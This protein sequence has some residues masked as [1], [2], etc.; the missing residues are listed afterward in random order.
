MLKLTQEMKLSQKLD[1]RM[2]Q[3]LKLLPLTTLQLTQRINEELEQNPLLQI[4]ETVEQVQEKPKTSNDEGGQVKSET[5]SESERNG[6]FTEAEWLKYM[7]DGYDNHYGTRQEYDP[8]VEERESIH[9]YTYGMTESLIEQLGMIAKTETDREIGEFIIGSLNDDGFLELTDEEIASDLNMPV[10]DISRM[11]SVIQQFDPPG[12]AARN[13]RECL[14]IQLMEK[15]MENSIAWKIIDKHFADL[16]GRKHKEILRSLQIS[17]NELK[18]AIDVIATLT[19]KP[20]GIFNDTSNTAIVPDILVEKLDGEYV[21]I[22]NDRYI[23]HLNINAHYR[24]LLEKGSNTSTDT[25]KYLVDKL[26]SAR[27]FINSIEQRRSTILRVST[28][29]IERQKEFLDHGISHLKP[30]TLQDIAENIGVAISTVQRVTTGKYIQTPQ[31]VFELKNFFTQR[32]ASSDGSDDYSAKTVK[33]KLKTL[34]EKE[35]PYKPLSDQ[36]IT[37]L[38][39]KEGISISRR[40]IAKYRDELQISPAR[41]RKQ[42]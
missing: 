27:W 2:I 41:L 12:I 18:K 14:L 39:N 20:G 8:N 37:D 10:E 33:D 22:L 29:I 5:T 30:M 32:I 40:A 36:K 19:P 26:N 25:R 6:D 38:L 9:T 16:T 15:G 31:G 11:V 28:A 4:D 35:D 24:K 34:I 42:F 21:V 13:L 3:S 1:F 17:E 23:P 7:E